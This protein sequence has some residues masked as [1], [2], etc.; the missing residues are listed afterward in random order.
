MSVYFKRGTK[1]NVIRHRGIPAMRYATL[2]NLQELPE[3]VSKRLKPI[4]HEANR[5][6]PF[7]DSMVMF[8]TSTREI[9]SVLSVFFASI[10]PNLEIG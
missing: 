7:N 1:R 4:K 3:A 8:Q 2:E 10:A 5:K 6:Q 9:Y